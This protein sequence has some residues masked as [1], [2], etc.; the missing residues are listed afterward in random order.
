MLPDKVTIEMIEAEI[1][2]ENYT[3][4]SH[5]VAVPARGYTQTYQAATACLT[6]CT[7][8]LKNGFTIVGKSSCISPEL[9]N[10]ELGKKYAREDAIRQIWPLMGYHLACLRQDAVHST[11]EERMA[12]EHAELKERIVKLEDF[13]YTSPVFET[14]VTEEKNDLKDQL[15]AMKS[16]E[17]TLR[18]RFD[19]I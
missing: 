13:I 4:G 6:L 7:L 1:V 16:Y 11:R 15:A 10:E 9:Y 5:L 8:V 3:N 17:D 18:R 19:R 2:S 14:L 12:K